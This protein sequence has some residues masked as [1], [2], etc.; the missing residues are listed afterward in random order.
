MGDDIVIRSIDRE[1]V[2]AILQSVLPPTAKIRVF[3]SRTKGTT[4][5]AADLNPAID[6]GRE[7]TPTEISDLDFA[8]VESELPYRVDVVNFVTTT[9]IFL[10]KYTARS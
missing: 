2:T 8:F 3:G 9:G 10:Q 7:L 4:K 6:D 5:R 1:V